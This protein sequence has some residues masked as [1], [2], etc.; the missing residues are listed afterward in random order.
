LFVSVF[1]Y[2]YLSNP[3]QPFKITVETSLHLNLA[4]G[5]EEAA[6]SVVTMVKPLGPSRYSHRLSA[7]SYASRTEH[8]FLSELYG[9]HSLL[10]H[11]FTF[12]VLF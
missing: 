6:C 10:C 9:N 3:L 11:E 1:V 2:E 7:R 12:L 8:R 4:L 5:C